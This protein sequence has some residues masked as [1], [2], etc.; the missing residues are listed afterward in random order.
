MAG[1]SLTCRKVSSRSDPRLEGPERARKRQAGEAVKWHGLVAMAMPH[2][3]RRGRSQR[4]GVGAKGDREWGVSQGGRRGKRA[5]RE[6][7]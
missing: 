7:K 4:E 1:A 6:R 2:E 3:G 5:A